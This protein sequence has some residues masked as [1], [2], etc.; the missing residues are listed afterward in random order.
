MINFNGSLL[1][2][3]QLVFSINE[4]IISYADSVKE[5]IRIVDGE[6]FLWEEHYFSLM[7]SMRIM[8]MQIP[9]NFTPEFFQNQI[10]TLLQ[11]KQNGCITFTCYRTASNDILE[12]SI[13]YFIVFDQQEEAWYHEVEEAEIDVYKDFVV[14]DSFFSQNN[15]VH[16]EENIA[17]VYAHENDMHDLVLLN[18]NKR[19]AK[20]LYGSIFLVNDQKIRT[21]KQAEGVQKSVLRNHF[22]TTL[23]KEKVFE[24]EETEIFPFEMQRAEEIFVLMDGYGMKSFTQNRKKTFKTEKTHEIFSLFTQS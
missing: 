8:R 7:A 18:A 15:I 19:M 6:I 21:P 4:R 5:V 11:N 10:K 1:P 13:G 22:I 23:N 20:S 12:S 14:N 3:E 2:Q 17:R 24:V 9:L 16:P